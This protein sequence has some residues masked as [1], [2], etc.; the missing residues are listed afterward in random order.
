M[1]LQGGLPNVIKE[2]KS[3]MI[4]KIGVCAGQVLLCLEAHQGRI[5]IGVLLS[6]ASAPLELILMAVGWLARESYVDIDDK[7]P[8]GVTISLKMN[9]PVSAVNRVC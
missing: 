4:T 8:Q 1:D 9:P 6:E 7:D 2:R 5:S 3:S